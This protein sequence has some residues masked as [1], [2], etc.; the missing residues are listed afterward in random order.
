MKEPFKKKFST[1]LSKSLLATLARYFPPKKYNEV[2]ID[3]VTV[4]MDGLSSGDVYV[5]MKKIPK[6][7]ELKYKGWPSYHMKA[8]LESGWTKGDNSPIV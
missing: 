5:D 4:L 2:L 1:D 3:V 7:L 8:L 6:N